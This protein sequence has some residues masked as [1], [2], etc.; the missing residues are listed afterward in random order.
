MDYLD[1]LEKLNE[2][3]PD[4]VIDIVT[5][6]ESLSQ[7][8]ES[9][10][11]SLK[12][13]M[14]I[15]QNREDYVTSRAIIDLQEDI[16]TKIADLNQVIS[17]PVLQLRHSTSSEF[18]EIENHMSNED[19]E[20]IDYSLYA[21]DETIAYDLLNTPVTKKRPAAFSFKGYKYEAMT[22]QEML[23]KLSGIL[24]RENPAIMKRLA[25]DYSEGKHRI[26]ISSTSNGMRNPKIIPGSNL[27][28]E[29]NKNALDICRTMG[30]LLTKYGYLADSVKVFIRRDYSLLHHDEER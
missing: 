6:I 8:L 11:A 9:A 10:K 3:V 14:L 29:T 22:W 26:S 21:T 1:L 30:K 23:L 27:Y 25:D 15:A 18:A 16:A 12:S 20:R 4:K 24:Y 17:S 5:V 13:N 28:F 7:E 2:Y 19:A